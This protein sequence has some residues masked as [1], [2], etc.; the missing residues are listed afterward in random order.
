MYQE[1]RFKGEYRINVLANPL[2]AVNGERPAC[3][4]SG[5]GC[6]FRCGIA[7][8]SQGRKGDSVCYGK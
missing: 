2:A 4:M 5:M 3:G 8:V 6:L 7:D 1:S